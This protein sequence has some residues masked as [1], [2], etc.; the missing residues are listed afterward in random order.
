MLTTSHKIEAPLIKNSSVGSKRNGGCTKKRY[1]IAV[2]YFST[3]LQ[4]HSPPVAVEELLV[5]DGSVGAEEGDGVQAGRVDGVLNK[6]NK[7]RY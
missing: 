3:R 4:A 5:E 7:S 6:Y 2:H 1:H